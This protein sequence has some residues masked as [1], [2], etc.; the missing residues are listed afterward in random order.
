MQELLNQSVIT[1][2][3]NAVSAGTTAVDSTILDMSGFD[4]VVFVVCLNTVTSGSV[5]T[6]TAMEN[7]SSSTSGATAVTNGA[8]ATITDSGGASSNGVFVSDV[9]R[10]SQRYVYANFTRTT[11]NAAIDSIIAVQ[12]RARNIPTTQPATVLASVTSTPEQ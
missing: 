2:V 7:T 12:Y 1:R 8:T 6:L 9:I 3:S 5:M 11:A 4:A 10:P